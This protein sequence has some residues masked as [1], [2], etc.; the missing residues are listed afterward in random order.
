MVKPL[1]SS[2]GG[3]GLIPGWEL[4]LHM[5]LKRET[6]TKNRSTTVTEAIKS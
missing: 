4:R 2:A 6:K 1:P 5:P 3:V